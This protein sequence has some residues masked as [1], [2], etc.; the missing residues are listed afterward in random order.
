M[1]EEIGLAFFT[2]SRELALTVDAMG[3]GVKN[4]I[5][6]VNTGQRSQHE[7]LA[8]GIPIDALIH[9]VAVNLGAGHFS[10]LIHVLR[11]RGASWIKVVRETY[12]GACIC[13]PKW[14]LHVK[15]AVG[16][17][18]DDYRL[19]VNC[20]AS[21]RGSAGKQPQVGDDNL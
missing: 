16:C 15:V 4:S 11:N 21:R 6:W 7:C 18:T 8:G 19:T 10:A 20:Q 5:V 13:I 17:Q 2:R 3:L 9:V 1:G 12:N 14:P